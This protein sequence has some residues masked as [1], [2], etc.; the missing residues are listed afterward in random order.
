MRRLYTLFIL[1]LIGTVT[2]FGQKSGSGIVGNDYYRVN[3]YMTERYIYVTDNKDY[4]DK[5]RDAE[6]FQALLLWK[7]LNKAVSDPATVIYIRKLSSTNYNLQSQGTGV[8]E[9]TGYSAK[10]TERDASNG[11]YEVSASSNGVTKYLTDNEQS[12][13]EQGLLGTNGKGTY[14]RWVVNRITKDHATNYFGV[15][16]TIQLGSKYYQP[17]YA[18]FPFRTASEGMHVYYASKLAGSEVTLKEIEGDIP[19]ATPVVIE[20]SSSNPSDNRL[21][22]LQPSSDKLSGNEF[23]GVY[24]CNAKRPQESVDAFTLF[25]ASSMRILTVSDGKL[26]MSDNADDHLTSARVMNWTTRKRY[27]ALCIPANTSYLKA[28]AG[29]PAV[30]SVKFEGSGIEDIIAEKNDADAVGVY[31]M[32]GIQ[33]RQ[34][35]NV[36]GLPAGLYIVGGVK[37][38]V[39]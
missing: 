24:F 12:D 11:I 14:R 28:D 35:N 38:A 25:D 22:I 32:S 26:V 18:A 27:D 8:Q 31:T 34:T 20:C 4:Y 13:D 1:G 36:E 33:L 10:V 21:E 9:L 2:V 17:F 7:D 29:T 30:L 3:N 19:G 16:P 23:V 6:D 37:V 5:T 39:K 15:K